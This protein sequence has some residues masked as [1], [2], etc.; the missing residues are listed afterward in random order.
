L[1]VIEAIDFLTGNSRTQRLLRVVLE[2]GAEMLMIGGLSSTRDEAHVL[3]QD[4][5][6]SGA[7]AEKFAEMIAFQGGPK[8][9]LE[10]KNSILPGAQFVRPVFADCGGYVSAIDTRA[11]GFSVVRL[12]GGR[13]RPGDPVDP[14]VGFS[15]LLSI[16]VRVGKD[17]PLAFIHADNETDWSL[18]A[19][20]IE[21]AYTISQLAPEPRSVIPGGFEASGLQCGSNLANLFDGSDS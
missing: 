10:N 20:R 21:S 13:R 1:E 19:Q 3:L 17:T 11:V 4:R 6:D 15:K 12:G 5:L 7:G 9:I 18:A 16:G 14:S 2:L 8:D